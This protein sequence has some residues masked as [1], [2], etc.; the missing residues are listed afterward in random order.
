MKFSLKKT[1]LK[2]SLIIS[3][4]TSLPLTGFIYGFI[5][6]SDCGNGISGFPGRI[7][8]GFL[9]SFFT[10]ISLGKPWV[11]G[12]VITSTNLRLYVLL[13]FLIIFVVI[14]AFRVL[15]QKI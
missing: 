8:L 7:L 6:C 11:G 2:A 9:Y 1:D 5:I 12:G 4:I 14:Y 10:L 13:S 3:T 15:K